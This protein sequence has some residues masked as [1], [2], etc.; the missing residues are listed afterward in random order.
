MSLPR[1]ENN[2]ELLV[3]DDDANPTDE[4][5]AISLEEDAADRDAHLEHLREIEEQKALARR[6]QPVQLGLPRPAN[7]DISRLLHD[8]NMNDDGSEQAAAQNL[9]N[10]ELA[11]LLSQLH[12]LSTTRDR[13]FGCVEIKL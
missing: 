6:S 3:P 2:F 11:Q 1:P 7:V 10:A 13:K 5:N 9:V 12:H 8:L 4:T